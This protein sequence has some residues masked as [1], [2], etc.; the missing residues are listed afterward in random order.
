MCHHSEFR[1]AASH[2]QPRHRWVE[3]I[4]DELV[5]DVENVVESVGEI[6]IGEVDVAESRRKVKL[7]ECE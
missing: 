5:G 2:R 3:E 1:E 7:T 4:E 6:E